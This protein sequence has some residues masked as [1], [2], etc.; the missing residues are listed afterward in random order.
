LSIKLTMSLPHGLFACA[1]SVEKAVMSDPETPPAETAPS[2]QLLPERLVRGYEAFLCGRF[3]REQD[4]FRHL[5]EAGQNPRIM[6]IGCCDSRVSPEVIFDTGPGE[7]FVVRNVANLV[8]P[9]APSDGLH[10]TSAALEYAALGLR[11]EHVVVMGHARCGGVRAY[12][13]SE[14]D[15]YQ[16]P[17]SAGDF[18]GKWM[19]LIEP[20]ASIVGPPS[21]PL[22]EY[23]ER[24]ALASVIQGLA[25]LRSFPS[26]A[27]LEKRGMLSL[28]GAYFSISDGRLL[29]LDETTGRFEAVGEAAHKKVLAEPR[30]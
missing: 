23:V 3:S 20:V 11:V 29:A 14:F 21:E 24:L 15:P 1:L 13:E 4:R 6:L 27:T 9:Y 8:P 26:V 25:N 28:H 16:R 12:A 5:A 7:L 22:D 19:S 18:I 2:R 10:G 17:L 30:F